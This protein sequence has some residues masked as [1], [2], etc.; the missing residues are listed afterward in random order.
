MIPSHPEKQIGPRE[1]ET[2]GVG[3]R[4]MDRVLHRFLMVKQ[5]LFVI[6]NATCDNSW[7]NHGDGEVMFIQDIADHAGWHRPTF[8]P[9]INKGFLVEYMQRE[10]GLTLTQAHNLMNNESKLAELK[11]LLN[12]PT[13]LEAFKDS[14]SK[15]N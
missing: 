15:T 5:D 2:M 12:D 13:A 11:K 7:R 1:I 4:Q 8:T 3:K 9:V 14:L 6:Q 10:L